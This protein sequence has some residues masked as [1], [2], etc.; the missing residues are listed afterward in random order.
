LR[1]KNK[2]MEVSAGRKLMSIAVKDYGYKGKE[3]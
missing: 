2:N 1:E 3:K